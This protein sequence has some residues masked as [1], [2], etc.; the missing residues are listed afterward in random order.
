MKVVLFAS[1]MLIATG[2]ALSASLKQKEPETPIRHHYDNGIA[3]LLAQI[4]S[5]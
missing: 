1:A 3:T 4:A 2:N 5:Y